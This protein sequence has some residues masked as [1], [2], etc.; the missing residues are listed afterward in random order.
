MK[1]MIVIFFFI[2]RLSTFPLTVGLGRNLHLEQNKNDTDFA[3]S[4]SS[5]LDLEYEDTFENPATLTN[6]DKILDQNKFR[7][8]KYFCSGYYCAFYK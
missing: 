2:T 1:P 3:Y 6:V 5:T 8:R 4:L 7:N